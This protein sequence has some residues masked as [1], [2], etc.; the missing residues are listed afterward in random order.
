MTSQAATAAQSPAVAAPSLWSPLGIRAFRMLWL[1]LLA[2]SISQGLFQTTTG[3]VMT[4]LSSSPVLISLV[5]TAALLPGLVFALPSGAVADTLNRRS[6]MLAVE[7]TLAVANVALAVLSFSD[8]LSGPLL[9]VFVLINGT[10]LALGGPAWQTALIETA[11]AEQRSSVVLLGGIAVSI[12]R[13]VGPLFAGLVLSAAGGATLSF[14][15]C[16]V[17]FSIAFLLVLAWPATASTAPR[18]S[19]ERV[20][21]AI[22]TGVR[23]AKNEPAMQVALRRV[24]VFVLAGTAYWSVVPLVGRRVIGFDALGF[25]LWM[26]A[27]GLGSVTGAYLM[28]RILA[29]LSL[30]TIVA[31]STVIVAIGVAVISLFP[32]PYVAYPAMYGVGLAWTMAISAFVVT[33]QT[34]VPSWVRSRA[35]AIYGMVFEGTIALAAAMWGLVAER[36]GVR[37]E[38]L[39]GAAALLVTL[40]V[41][42]WWKLSKGDSTLLTPYG[43]FPELKWSSALDSERTRALVMFEYTIK[44][45]DR[46]RFIELMDAVGIVRRRN[47]VTEWGLYQDIVGSDRWIEE[48]I[49]DSLDEMEN[50]RQRTT[51]ADFAALQEAYA[52]HSGDTPTPTIRRLI[53]PATST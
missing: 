35:M 3:W 17:G 11:P 50:I 16:A 42:L 49:V 34:N 26:M 1:A 39:V 45:A 32:V 20:F 10:A 47:G 18:L 53:A 48:F 8:L 51:V 14:A 24:F 25:G 6:I 46:A 37:N 15:L 7:G 33:V 36:L 31:I 9:L 2:A 28:S 30:N 27:F 23:F 22:L 38:L 4:S 5:Q 41:G 43:Q 21:E 40:P 19:A 13:G 52:L 44:E 29:A 12:S